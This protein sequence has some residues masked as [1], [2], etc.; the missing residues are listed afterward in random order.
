MDYHALQQKLFEMDP[1]DPADDIR[2]I[3]EMASENPTAVTESFV[4]GHGDVHDIPQGSAPIDK[5]YSISD[6]AKLAGV[7]LNEASP[8]D[9]LKHGFKNYNKVDALNVKFDAP[10]KK[11]TVAVKGKPQPKP[12]PKPGQ[13]QPKPTGWPT[14]AEGHTL[15]VGDKVTYKNA[16]GQLR[17]DV[18]VLGLINGKVDGDGKPQIQLGMK[19]A[20]YAI[21]RKQISAVNGK[22]FTLVDAKAGTGKIE[23]LEARISYLEEVIATLVEG[24]KKPKLMK[25]RDPNAQYMN[26]LRKSGAAGSHKD[27]TKTIPRKQKHKDTNESIKS[28]LWAALKAK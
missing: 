11:P 18:P 8:L 7:Q 28:Q 26:D 12:K 6:F 21:S 1:A 22:P 17:K 19:G 4:D 3:T 16:K 20:V 15:A 23:A 10:E 25:A 13:P 14:S 27:K 24:K 9:A 2:K 5:D